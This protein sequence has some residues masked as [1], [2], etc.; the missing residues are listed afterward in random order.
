MLERG[1][2]GHGWAGAQHRAQDLR[3]LAPVILVF[4]M[5]K[6]GWMWHHFY[7]IVNWSKEGGP[8]F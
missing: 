7:C 1:S 8:S 2:K 3:E 6:I 5:K 4:T